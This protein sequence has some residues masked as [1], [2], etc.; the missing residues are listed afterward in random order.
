MNRQ[1]KELIKRIDELDTWIR[2]DMELGCGFAPPGAYD[3]TYKE[4]YRLQEK[5]AHLRHYK[6][7]E[8]MFFDERGQLADAVQETLRQPPRQKQAKGQKSR[9]NFRGMER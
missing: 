6:G 5:L 7:V 8:D 1:K 3:E 4:I 9:K 2:I